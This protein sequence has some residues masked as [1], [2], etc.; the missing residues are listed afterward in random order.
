[1]IDPLRIPFHPME[2]M[3]MPYRDRAQV[4]HRQIRAR[5]SAKKT[6]RVATST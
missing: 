2:S 6:L 4:D 5:E 3:T 1:M